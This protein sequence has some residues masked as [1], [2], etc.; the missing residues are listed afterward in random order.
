MVKIT[1][2]AISI[3]IVIAAAIMLAPI[4]LFEL[5]AAIRHRIAGEGDAAYRKQ[6][7]KGDA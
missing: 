2:A 5:C 4:I 6:R 7:W 1:K 3:V